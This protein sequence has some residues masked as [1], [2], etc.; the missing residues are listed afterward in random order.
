MTGMLL[1]AITKSISSMAVKMICARA[2]LILLE[3]LSVPENWS[4]QLGS[5]KPAVE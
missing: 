3:M 2:S 5:V 4:K 1:H